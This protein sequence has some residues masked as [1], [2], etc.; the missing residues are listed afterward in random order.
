M[1]SPLINKFHLNEK[2][3]GKSVLNLG[4][5]GAKFTAKNVVNLDGY[6]ICKPDVLWN[7][8]KTPLP[9]EDDSFDII[10]AHHIFE[11]V[12]NWWSLFNDAARILKPLG[13]IRI[14]VPYWSSASALGYRD[15]V[16]MINEWSFFGC[17]NLNRVGT[18][19]WAATQKK[20]YAER[21][22]L[23][24][25]DKILRHDKWWI[26]HAP[27]F[28][29]NWMGEFLINC[30]MECEISFIK[31]TTE[32]FSK[33]RGYEWQKPQLDSIDAAVASDRYILKT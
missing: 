23:I 10:I 28:I 24:K 32:Q 26:K 5:G 15:H 20:D 13:V 25:F 30:V 3:D 12:H 18:N 4:C 31:V 9:F 17:Y 21:L 16:T 27:N 11:H 33:E 14:F 22:A 2:F 8:E 29:K 1:G 6:A 19:A 7:L